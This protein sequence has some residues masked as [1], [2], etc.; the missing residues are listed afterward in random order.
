MVTMIYDY[1]RKKSLVFFGSSPMDT[2]PEVVIPGERSSI[3]AIDLNDDGKDDLV[4]ITFPERKFNV[5]WGGSQL[6]SIPDLI[7]SPPEYGGWLFR[8]NDFNGDSRNEFAYM[9]N[10]QTSNG[11]TTSIRNV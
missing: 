8:I 3:M 2:I 4:Y 6:D 5:Y 7:F 10:F 1:K 9:G 11:K